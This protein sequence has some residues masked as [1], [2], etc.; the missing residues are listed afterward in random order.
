MLLQNSHLISVPLF[1]VPPPSSSIILNMDFSV[2]FLQTEAVVCVPCDSTTGVLLQCAAEAFAVDVRAVALFCD[3]VQVVP[4][5]EYGTHNRDGHFVEGPIDSEYPPGCDTPLSETDVGSVLTLKIVLSDAAL[6]VH[7]LAVEGIHADMYEGSLRAACSVG[8]VVTYRRLLATG[9][10]LSAA[11]HGCGLDAAAQGGH[12]AVFCALRSPPHGARI[13]Q[14]VWGMGAVAWY[15]CAAARCCHTTLVQYLLEHCDKGTVP[16]V[17]SVGVSIWGQCALPLHSAVQ[18]HGN[19]S[20]VNILLT[21]GAE[22][23]AFPPSR[24]GH[25]MNCLAVALP[26]YLPLFTAAR[27][28]EQCRVSLLVAG[29]RSAIQNASSL[30][31]LLALREY[32]R[33]A[34]EVEC[35]GHTGHTLHNYAALEEA[36]WTSCLRR[37]VCVYGDMR[38]VLSGV[39]LERRCASMVRALL[40]WGCIGAKQ[41]EAH[42]DFLDEVLVMLAD[43]RSWTLLAA[44]SNEGGADL[45]KTNASGISAA[46]L[47]ARTACGRAFLSRLHIEGVQANQRGPGWRLNQ[48]NGSEAPRFAYVLRRRGDGGQNAHHALSASENAVPF[49]AKGRSKKRAAFLHIAHKGRKQDCAKG[50]ERTQ[51]RLAQCKRDRERNMSRSAKTMLRM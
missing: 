22:L 38:N 12:T 37:P 3:G 1:K 13:P 27:F 19:A 35:T 7:I 32:H 9:V 26:E 51:W 33:V 23:R 21:E 11:A 39:I 29:D 43:C 18:V 2:S 45:C 17:A 47:A 49:D 28:R 4:Y 15:L 41:I 44:L 34:F 48:R 30:A 24:Y 31:S 36:S 6:A 10:L 40:Q 5:T 25:D 20:I 14:E 16:L 42:H 46:T 8:D 50:R